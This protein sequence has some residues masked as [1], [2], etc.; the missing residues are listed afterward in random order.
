MKSPI[1]I[2]VTFFLL[3]GIVFIACKKGHELPIH[4]GHGSITPDYR[5][6]A[7]CGGYFIKFDNDTSVIYHSF[8]NLDN[9]GVTSNSKFPVRATISWKPDTSV[10]IPNFITITS[11]RIDR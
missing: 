2:L 7:I 1:L 6:C 10:T 9:F 8:Q 5:A 3:T 4:T 11:L